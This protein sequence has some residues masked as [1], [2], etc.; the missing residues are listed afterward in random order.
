MSDK[1]TTR[2]ASLKAITANVQEIQANEIATN[3]INAS[4]IKL[5]GQNITDVIEQ[6]TSSSG[7]SGAEIPLED[8]VKRVDLRKLK[9]NGYCYLVVDDYGNLIGGNLDNFEATNL[10]TSS[11][12]YTSNNLHLWGWDDFNID[13]PNLVNGS[14]LFAGNEN[15]PL[16]FSANVDK[17]E[18]GKNMFYGSMIC[19]FTSELPNL[20]VADNMFFYCHGLSGESIK[21]VLDC[22]KNRNSMSTTAKIDFVKYDMGESVQSWLGSLELYNDVK[23]Y[24]DTIQTDTS[25]KLSGTFTNNAGG[26]WTARIEIYSD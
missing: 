25:D 8:K 1:Y 2:T 19:Q 12:G 18:N 21:H 3:V 7:N 14:Y 4:S 20:K 23:S 17:L 16:T 22:L 6:A 15:G 10:P 24:F 13:M 5:N 9:E 26:V 11:W